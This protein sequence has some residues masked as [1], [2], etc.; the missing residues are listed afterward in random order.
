MRARVGP[1]DCPGCG[2]YGRDDPR[3]AAVSND[4]RFMLSMFLPFVFAASVFVFLLGRHRIVSLAGRTI[5]FE[6]FFP[7]L[8]LGLAAIDVLYNATGFVR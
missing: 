5:L 1:G 3:Y 7:A 6:R 8:F 4:A 2:G